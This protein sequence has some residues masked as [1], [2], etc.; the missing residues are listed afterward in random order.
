MLDVKSSFSCWKII[1]LIRSSVAPSLP[2]QDPIP[3]QCL[4]LLLLASRNVMSV[5][6][7]DLDVFIVGFSV[8]VV[9]IVTTM[10]ATARISGSSIGRIVTV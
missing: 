2:V 9:I 6:T 8:V 1:R 10:T 5:I 4:S 7:I 3:E